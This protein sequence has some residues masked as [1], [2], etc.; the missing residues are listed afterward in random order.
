MRFLNPKWLKYLS[1][2][3]NISLVLIWFILTTGAT[4]N[5]REKSKASREQRS[6]L[7][8]YFI[9][10]FFISLALYSFASRRGASDSVT[11]SSSV[12]S[13]PADTQN[14]SCLGLCG[15]DNCPKSYA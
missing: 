12:L 9:I 10:L 13:S 6:Y 3:S 5:A 11:D 8:V 7:Y 1:P 2:L 15:R 4:G 14:V